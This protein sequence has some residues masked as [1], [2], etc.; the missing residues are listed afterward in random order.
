M[1]TIKAIQTTKAESNTLTISAPKSRGWMPP[2]TKTHK[3]L[4]HEFKNSWHKD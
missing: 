3:N 4:R 1:K 2:P